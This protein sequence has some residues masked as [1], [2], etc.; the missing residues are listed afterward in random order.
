MPTVRSIAESAICMP[1]SERSNVPGLVPGPNNAESMYGVG[2]SANRW[3][4]LWFVF[5]V[6]PH[7]VIVLK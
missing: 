7:T 1:K 3:L 2:L 6:I 4:S 5:Y